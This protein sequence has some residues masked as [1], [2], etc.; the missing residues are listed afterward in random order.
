M[1]AGWSRNGRSPR[2]PVETLKLVVPSP[3]VR[4]AGAGAQ[5]RA[6]PL[7]VV[8]AG[9]QGHPHVVPVDDV[10]PRLD[11]GVAGVAVGRRGE[12]RVVVGHQQVLAA[13]PGPGQVGAQRR[14]HRLRL[15]RVVLPERGRQAH[16]V[17]RPDVAGPEVTRPHGRVQATARGRTARS[18][19]PGRC[20]RSTAGSPARRSRSSS[21]ASGRRCGTSAGAT[22]PTTG[23]TRRQQRRA[24]TDGVLVVTQPEH[25]VRPGGRDRRRHPPRRGLRRRLAGVVDVADGCHDHGPRHDRHGRRGRRRRARRRRG[26]DGARGHR[27]RPRRRTR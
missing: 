23:R 6:G 19:D 25:Q 20:R 5:H 12:V 7:V 18:S 22:L 4:G 27:A 14:G 16:Q 9:G 3:G 17:P 8:L 15:R 26:G 10:D 21:R 24:R 1:K 11:V 2:P 13:G